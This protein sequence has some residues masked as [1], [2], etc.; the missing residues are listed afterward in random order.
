DRVHK[1]VSFEDSRIIYA[2]FAYSNLNLVSF[3]DCDIQNSYLNDSN[4]AKVIFDNCSLNL[5]DFH[6][7]SL[8]HIDLSNNNIEDIKLEGSELKGAIVS[9]SQTMDVA[10]FLGI[11][12]K[13]NY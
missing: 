9:L 3:K 2:N 6:N 1:N 7:T 8:K 13:D 4:V 12:I 11:V 5:T 10:R